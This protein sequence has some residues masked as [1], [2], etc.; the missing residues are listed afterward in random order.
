MRTYSCIQIRARLGIALGVWISLLILASSLRATQQDTGAPTVKVK[1]FVLAVVD[2]ERKVW[3]VSFTYSF[4]GREDVF[5]E[6][7]G[8]IAPNGQL[9]YLT[10]NKQLRFT[11][12]D[13][14]FLK[15]MALNR[16]GTPEGAGVELP[17]AA[18]FGDTY[19]SYNRARAFLPNE[20][21]SNLNTFFTSGYMMD[22]K[23]KITY[24]TTSYQVIKD[25]VSR[26]KRAQVAL[27]VSSP[28]AGPGRQIS[29]RMQMLVRERGRGEEDTAWLTGSQISPETQSAAVKFRDKVVAVLGSTK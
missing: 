19:L 3:R 5:L 2:G 1:R 27:R 17:S 9:T 25:G 11:D 7:V 23:D 8:R 6:G 13:G 18:D 14:K 26:N 28:Y 24:Y 12:A 10:E 16:T 29:Y 21:G 20:C 15:S 22:L 4:P